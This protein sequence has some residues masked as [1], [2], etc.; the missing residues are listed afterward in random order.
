MG[1]RIYESISEELTETGWRVR[2]WRQEQS[3]NDCFGSRSDIIEV[4]RGNC[5][6]PEAIRAALEAMERAS[7]ISAIEIKDRRGNGG[8]I[9]PSWP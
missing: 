4:I 7:D 6:N 3:F 5:E 9:Y 8:V 1:E 2:V